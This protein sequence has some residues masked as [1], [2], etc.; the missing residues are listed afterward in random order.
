[1][2]TGLEEGLMPTKEK[3]EKQ[4]CP[5]QL[6][7]PRSSISVAGASPAL[8]LHRSGFLKPVHSAGVY[9]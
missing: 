3:V 4:G 5:P 2:R 1:M 6:S 7:Q 9:E 8:E